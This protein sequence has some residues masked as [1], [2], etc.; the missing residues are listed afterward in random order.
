MY[1]IKIRIMSIIFRINNTGL[2]AESIINMLKALS[3]DYDFIEMS[4]SIDE[5]P[6]LSDKE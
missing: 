4:E 2:K 1:E 5:L 6:E 3:A